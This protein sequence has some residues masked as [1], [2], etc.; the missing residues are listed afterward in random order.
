M[1]SRTLNDFW[2]FSGNSNPALSAKICDFL[3]MPLG[4]AK[5]TTFS[6]G[7]IQIKSPG[8]MLGYYKAPEENAK[9]FIMLQESQELELA[10][11][12][13]LVGNFSSEKELFL[14]FSRFAQQLPSLPFYFER[15]DPPPQLEQREHGS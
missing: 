9:A 4:G 5:V 12:A 10:K 6:D 8:N 1:T 13:R 15:K 3:K 14:L 11:S 2:I 7:E